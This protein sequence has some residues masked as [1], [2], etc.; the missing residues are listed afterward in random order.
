MDTIARSFLYLV[1]KTKLCELSKFSLT[2]GLVV[3]AGVVITGPISGA[4]LNPAVTVG[5][6]AAGR[7]KLIRASLYI[8]VQCVGGIGMQMDCL[9]Q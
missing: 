3:F 1:L 4:N 7:V 5:L 6:F 2:F 9:L 8:I